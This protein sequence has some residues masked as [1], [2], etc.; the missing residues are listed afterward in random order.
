MEGNRERQLITFLATED[1]KRGNSL[2]IIDAVGTIAVWTNSDEA[3]KKSS[4]G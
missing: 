3:K 2:E 1:R 4:E